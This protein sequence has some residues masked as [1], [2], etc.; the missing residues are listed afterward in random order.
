VRRSEGC[1]LGL[2][3]GAGTLNHTNNLTRDAADV[4]AGNPGIGST[5]LAR[6]L[7]RKRFA[8]G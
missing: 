8:S 3:V 7:G 4:T 2:L 5:G 6:R 1:R